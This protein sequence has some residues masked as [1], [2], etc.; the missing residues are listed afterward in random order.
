[1]KDNAFT[2]QPTNLPMV[3]E[4]KENVIK[5]NLNLIFSQ[6]PKKKFEKI[7]KKF[8]YSHFTITMIVFHDKNVPVIC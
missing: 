8:L 6:L 7:S 4:M 3:G 2:N 1:M 5:I